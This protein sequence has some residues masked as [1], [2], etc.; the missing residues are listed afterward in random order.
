ARWQLRRHHR[1]LLVAATTVTAPD[2]P[3]DEDLEATRLAWIARL[4]DLADTLADTSPPPP[5]AVVAAELRDLRSPVDAAL[6]DRRLVALAAA[7]SDHA[8][9]SSRGEL[10]RQGLP[11]A[12]ALARAVGTLLG[13]RR[14]TP[15]ELTTRIRARFPHA[16]LLPDDQTTLDRL[17]AD[18]GLQLR[19]EPTERAWVAP[20]VS[21]V[22]NTATHTT[23]SP[24][25]AEQADFDERLRLAHDS[26]RLLV[27]QA[28]T[29]RYRGAIDRL[30]AAGVTPLSVDEQLI[31]LLRDHATRLG[32]DWPV[33][34]DADA[35][36]IHSTDWRNLTQL[37]A[38]AVPDLESAILA[39][40]GTVL[41]CDLGL[42]GRYGQ[43]SLVDR[44]RSAV[45]HGTQPLRSLWVLVAH[46][47]PA[48][49]PS[50]D[51][52]AIGVLTPN[53]W[54][55]IPRRWIDREDAA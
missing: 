26:G 30:S 1:R 9:V 39:I 42:L 55:R 52:H 27:L 3:S 17:L 38:R 33:V 6:D 23:A 20:T 41:L 36:G 4:G 14:L 49:G 28:P 15:A 10:Y 45:A 16:E 22:A 2:E 44:L 47:G 18:A 31:S 8:A 37:V 46:D 35:A 11:A 53:E 13:V 29:S 43:L 51:G 21:V 7:A 48:A 54:A 25:A 12:E 19:W 34:L 24:E 32:I 5:P 50:V 40:K